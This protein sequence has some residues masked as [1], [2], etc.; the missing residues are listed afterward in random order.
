MAKRIGL[1]AG[2]FDPIHLGHTSF[3]RRAIED[4]RLDKV[5]V[6]VERAPKFKQC[7]ASY[8]QRTT[9][10]ELALKNIPQAEIYESASEFF[11]ITSSLPA[12]KKANPD[13]GIYLLVGND[14]AAHMDK[15]EATDELA[16][17]R[18]IIAERG[19]AVPYSDV[20]SLKIRQKRQAGQDVELDP[21][22]LAYCEDNKLY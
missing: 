19:A 15:W 9:M 20:S 8:E 4:N 22:V 12:I 14:V 3:I 10:A 18:L 11:P 16:D 1:F 13:A 21:K 2:V 17:I 5:F 7:I 6:L